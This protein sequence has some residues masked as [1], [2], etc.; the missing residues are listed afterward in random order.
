[1]NG[2][3][4]CSLDSCPGPAVTRFVQRE[5]CSQHFLSQC[6][7]DLDRLDA[8]A[9]SSQ[10]DHCGAA[11]LKIFVEE[12]SRCALEVSLKCEHLDNLMRARLL[13]IL[14]WA[15]ELLPKTSTDARSAGESLCLR[16]T[17]RGSFTDVSQGSVGPEIVGSG[18]ALRKN[19][20]G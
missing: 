20:A 4:R 5:L 3:G 7:E 2:A 17:K 1:M 16:G 12:C 8:R 6:Y 19:A 14:L 15:A 9:R 10:L 18:A 13:D 11:T